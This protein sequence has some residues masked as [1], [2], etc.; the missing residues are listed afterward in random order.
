M[1]T[2]T[3]TAL[4]S[5]ALGV[6][7][8]WVATLVLAACA[9]QAPATGGVAPAGGGAATAPAPAAPTAAPAAKV[10][11]RLVIAVPVV[12]KGFADRFATQEWAT[13]RYNMGRLIVV[14]EKGALQ[15]WLALSWQP[16]QPTVWQ[17]KLRPNV[18]WQNGDPFSAEDVKY[19]LEFM[20]NPDNKHPQRERIK[21]VQ[22]VE[23]VDPLTVNVHTDGPSATLP[24]NMPSF[25]EVLPAKYHRE[26]GNDGFDARPIGV[27]PYK[28]KEL[29]P[30][31]SLTFERNEL[32]W[33]EPGKFREV[34]FRAIP[35][36]A[37]RLAALEAGEVHVVQNV[38][39]ENAER[40][41]GKGLNVI[42]ARE[43]RVMT[44]MIACE[45]PNGKPICDE[46][47][48]QAM[49]YAI[50]KEGISEALYGGRFPVAQ[51]Q[52]LNDA[53]FG[54]NPSLKPYP[55]DVKKAKEL[56]AAAGYANGFRMAVDYPAG[57]Y[58]KGQELMETIAAQWREIGIT[59]ELIPEDSGTWLNRYFNAKTEEMTIV[60]LGPTFDLDVA[61]NRFASTNP[62]K[63]YS[64]PEFD[65]LY[66]LQRTTVDQ[67]QR[68]SIA[69]QLL[70]HWH[71]KAVGIPIVEWNAFWAASP[72]VKN[73]SIPPDAAI[74]LISISME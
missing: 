53:T 63:F 70:Q 40:L 60:T 52:P 5:R 2:R 36:E 44:L 23:I 61:V 46:R 65:R 59:L 11:D 72:R 4:E 19:S 21:E 55:Y 20:V 1:S 68:L 33:G 73:V 67:A 41:K 69:H 30:G 16:I 25:V 24:G 51:G 9:P 66:A 64:D 34:V 37:T 42:L 17:F 74:D 62:S 15:P 18:K 50:D 57:R 6:V 26:V 48:R 8:V 13:H 28:A 12:S 45:R 43:N 38:S 56:M 32:F 31:Q 47:V 35:E 14:D 7:I 22:W 27:G 39:P 3:R 58:T 71:D 49:T 29:I 10:A 54:F